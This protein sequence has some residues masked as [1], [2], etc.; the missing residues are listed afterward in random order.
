MQY[1]RNSKEQR[2]SPLWHLFSLWLWPS[3]VKSL[4]LASKPTSP[5]KCPVLGREQHY[6]LISWKS[7]KIIPFFFF[8]SSRSTPETSR[9]TYEDFFFFWERLKSRKICNIFARRPFLF[10]RTLLR[11]CPRSL[12]ASISVLGFERV[13]PRKF[14]PW[15]WIF[16]VLG[17]GLEPF[18]LDSISG[19]GLNVD[20]C[21]TPYGI[22]L[23]VQLVPLILT[24][25]WWFKKYWAGPRMP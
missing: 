2:W 16:C 7:A 20:P 14:C 9:M 21:A 8:S 19:K 4:V 10:W 15:P 11:L 13:C 12:A 23:I 24:N 3:K 22:A 17:L 25:C 6:F 5:R 1:N 18:V